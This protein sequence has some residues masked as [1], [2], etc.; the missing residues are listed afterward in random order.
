MDILFSDFGY[1]KIKRQEHLYSASNQCLGTFTTWEL[2]AVIFP[3][4]A[5]QMELSYLPYPAP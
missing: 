1:F 5:I 3:L 4:F 2:E